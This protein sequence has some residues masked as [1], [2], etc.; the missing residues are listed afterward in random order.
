MSTDVYTMY[1]YTQPK[2]GDDLKSDSDCM[3]RAVSIATNTEYS[4]VYDIMY[5]HG[6][7][8]SR[9]RGKG[10]F[11]DH[12]LN[13]LD[14]LGYKAIKHSFPAVKGKSRMT[15]KQMIMEGYNGTYIMRQ[16]KHVS[17]LDNLIIKDTWDTRNRCV[18]YAWE[19]VEK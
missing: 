13:T 19:I 3:I 4:K 2:N 8:V 14:D 1:E 12:I 16:A 5:S 15:A 10:K 11:E 7:R 9:G 17:V 18:Y 6:Y